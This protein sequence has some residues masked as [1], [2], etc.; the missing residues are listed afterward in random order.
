MRKSLNVEKIDKLP[1]EPGVYFLKNKR[2]EIFYIGK[3][4]N[5][6]S[7]VQ[8]HANNKQRTINSE[9]W[10]IY[11]VEWI[12]CANEI[13]V[14]IKEAEYIK[15]YDPKLNIDLKD[16]KKYSYVGI[17]KE[18]LPRIFITHQ[19][20]I[21][22]RISQSAYRKNSQGKTMRDK[23]LAPSEFIGPFTDATALHITLRYLRKIFPYYT[24]S[25]KRPLASP[26]HKKLPCS[27]CHIKLCPGP[28][29]DKTAYRKN[30]RAMKQILHG[31]K[32]T[33]LKKMDKEMRGASHKKMYEEAATLRDTIN[34]IEKVFSH[35]SATAPPL[36]TKNIIKQQAAKPQA[37]LA[38]L[39][40][41]DLP[42]TS[43]EGYD[44][45]NIQGQEPTASMVRF[46]NGAPNKSLYRKFNIHSLAQP[47]DYLM[48]REV[49]RRRFSHRE[50]PYPDLIL[51][52]GGR[53]QLNSAQ[54]ELAKLGL[55]IKLVSLA[56]RLEELFIPGRAKPI[57]LSK[58]PKE[59]E[60]LLKHIRDEAH[61]FAI[62]H[63]R[64]R[65]RKVFR[66]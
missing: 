63:H 21:A 33:L 42:I 4:N 60:N 61:R 45:S 20:H 50:W 43:I 31:N 22:G 48:M 46:D 40:K 59:T 38:K 17:T 47:N 10:Q 2:G 9:Q 7:R 6:R 34:A 12:R 36:E 54:L 26:H 11:S 25:P 62:S 29:P 18:D 55:Q 32:D 24:T 15:H 64:K 56:K 37:Y 1:S 30:I 53:G 14:L 52:D 19:P 66:K 49:I 51:I 27:Y 5:L 28:A 44:I 57:L 39:L 13:E 16:D 23:R 41:T 58:M 35:Y 8:T 65:H 3:A